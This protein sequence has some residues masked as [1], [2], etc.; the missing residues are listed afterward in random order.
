MAESAGPTIASAAGGPEARIS[1]WPLSAGPLLPETGAS[2]NR[3]SG[4]TLPSRLVIPA[5]ASKPIVATT[6]PTSPRAA[7]AD[8]ERSQHRRR[9][10]GSDQSARHRSAHDSGA[11]R[12]NSHV[13]TMIARNGQTLR[14]RCLMQWLAVGP[15]ARAS[16][17]LEAGQGPVERTS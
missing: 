13:V 9:Q 17:R 8:G 11:E 7:V 12:G 16:G 6:A 14:P 15:G 3:T 5:V 1:S 2:T 4:R 10:P